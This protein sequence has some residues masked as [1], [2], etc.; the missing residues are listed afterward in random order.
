MHSNAI[1]KAKISFQ[2]GRKRPIDD[3]R[4]KVLKT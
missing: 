2:T 4:K 1:S 3:S